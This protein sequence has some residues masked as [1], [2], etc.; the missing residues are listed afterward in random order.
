M[1]LVSLSGMAAARG[2]GDGLAQLL[3]DEHHAPMLAP[4]A[5]QAAVEAVLSNMDILKLLFGQLGLLDLCKVS[6][7]CQAWRTVSCSDEFWRDVS[8][9]GRFM[10]SE[11]VLPQFTRS[12]CKL[13]CKHM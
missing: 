6:T 2:A 3:A 4:V 8:F 1:T 13:Y 7:V 5:G 9:E 11:Q 12:C 10:H